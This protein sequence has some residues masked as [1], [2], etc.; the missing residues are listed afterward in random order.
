MSYDRVVLACAASGFLVAFL[1]F[2]FFGLVL[3]LGRNGFS[4][5]GLL[6]NIDNI[7][8]SNNSGFSILIFVFGIMIAIHWH[9]SDG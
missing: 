4:Q 1:F 9:S 6:V 3:L 2:S 5:Q 7:V 8:V